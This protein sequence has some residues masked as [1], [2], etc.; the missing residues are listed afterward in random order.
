MEIQVL[1]IQ[2]SRVANGSAVDAIRL[3]KNAVEMLPFPEWQ[4]GVTVKAKDSLVAYA[5]EDVR[6]GSSPIIIMVKFKISGLNTLPTTVQI[7]ATEPD[8]YINGLP[9]EILLNTHVNVLGKVKERDVV[10]NENGETDWIPFELMN[11]RLPQWGVGIYSVTW[12]WQQFLDTFGVWKDIAVTHHQVYSLVGKP[13]APWSQV[14]VG[15]LQLPWTD[16]LDY[17]CTWASKSLSVDEAAAKI[18]QKIFSMAPWWFEYNCINFFPAYVQVIGYTGQSFFN[19]ME[20]LQHLRTRNVNRYII[21]SDCAAIVS[22]FAN[23]LGCD[24][25]QSTMQ[26]PGTMFRTNRILA[27]GS[28]YWQTPCGIPGFSYHEVAWKGNGTSSDPI[29]DA[30]LALDATINPQDS[31]S[32]PLLP[33]NMM[34]GS[35][36][37]G[38]YRDKLVFPQDWN[39]AKPTPKDRQRRLP[40]PSINTIRFGPHAEAATEKKDDARV[41]FVKQQLEFDKWKNRNQLSETLLIHQF[42]LNT[43]EFVDWDIQIFA[44]LE[45]NQHAPRYIH[46]LW[47]SRYFLDEAVRVDFYECPSRLKAQEFLTRLLVNVHTTI[48]VLRPFPELGDIAFSSSRNKSVIFTRANLVV[49]MSKTNFSEIPLTQLGKQIDE[50]LYKKPIDTEH[51]KVLPQPKK[52]RTPPK[53]GN[54]IALAQLLEL[55]KTDKEEGDFSLSRKEHTF[56][57]IYSNAKDLSIEKDNLSYQTVANKGLE[58]SVYSVSSNITKEV[59]KIL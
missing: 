38:L 2:F 12:K 42:F 51:K 50:H 56:Y 18:T 22:T 32:V 20:F 14:S 39:L 46:S 4:R 26:T 28:P 29:F 52:G 37:S 54:R 35:K 7:R 3:R 8:I 17:A 24:L 57:K 49:I 11:V 48:D 45:A 10:L 55:M 5:I 25:W 13:T 15:D 23:S 47:R 31:F 21:C 41:L 30:C 33:V 58:V 34:L 6:T 27:I 43:K 1:A 44:Q 16:V 36:G 59:P 40:F 53:K 19:C 9:W